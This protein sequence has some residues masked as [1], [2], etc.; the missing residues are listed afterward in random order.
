MHLLPKSFYSS[1]IGMILLLGTTEVRS[2][3]IEK[4]RISLK[5]HYGYVWA[6]RPYMQVFNDGHVSGLELSLSKRLFGDDA[7][8]SRLLNPE[9][10]ISL[11]ALDLGN[12]QLLGNGYGL[13]WFFSFPLIK[14]S[15]LE[16]N[17]LAGQGLGLVDK[18]FEIKDN[19]KNFANSTR[20][21]GFVYLSNTLG[22]PVTK[23][24]VAE[25]GLSF[26]HFSNGG[27]SKPNLGLNIP[28]ISLGVDY[29]IGRIQVDS[30]PP[31]KKDLRRMTTVILA[32]G[33]K[34][35][36]P[37]QN[38]NY[39]AYS[40]N[41]TN[42]YS[43]NDISYFGVGADLFSDQALKKEVAKEGDSNV[44]FSDQVRAGIH[45]SYIFKTKPIHFVIDHGFYLHSSYRGD[46]MMYN[47]LGARYR[48]TEQFF[49]N[50]TL[51]THF[52]VADHFEFGIL[53]RIK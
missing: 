17:L 32:F 41:F 15:K 51:K 2:G 50:T 22:I 13:C 35:R 36:N 42:Y 43:R 46:G 37:A 18:K 16:Y 3:E 29:K 38:M 11:M 5:S 12:K 10:G 30:I 48:I 6:H 25:V 53:Y 4:Y 40:L 44:T 8:R 9:F 19:F 26:I 45:V 21:N 39:M 28:A 1:I 24:L 23:D 34:E 27:N 47:R 49:L 7:W 20:L 14:N 52:A 31:K 33:V